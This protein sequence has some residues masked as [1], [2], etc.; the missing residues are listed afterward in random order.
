MSQRDYVFAGRGG[1]GIFRAA[2]NPWPLVPPESNESES[3]AS[4]DGRLH[5]PKSLH[6]AK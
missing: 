2:K 3:G 5:A 6:L 4:G 1:G